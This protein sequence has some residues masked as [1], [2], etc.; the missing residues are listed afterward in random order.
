MSVRY[1]NI[2]GLEASKKGIHVFSNRGTSGIDGCS[3]TAVG[4]ALSSE[5]PNFLI[6]GDIAFFYDRNAYWH[7]YPMPNLHIMLLNN[8]G[9][10]IFNMI[11]GPANLPESKEYFITNQRLSAKQLAAEFDF[12][13]L[14]LDNLRKIKNTINDFFEFNGRTKVLEIETDVDLNKK[15]VDDFKNT[16][17]KEYET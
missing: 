5:V 15:I 3:S 1:A 14:K 12:D 11:D 4:H 6:T 17:K 8:H 2:I 16:L 9:G 7:N 13:Y 10:V